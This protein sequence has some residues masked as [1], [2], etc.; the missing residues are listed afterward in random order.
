MT[1][2]KNQKKTRSN[3]NKVA[4]YE[5]LIYRDIANARAP[6]RVVTVVLAQQATLT[7]SAGGVFAGAFSMDPS[8]SAEWA[9]FAALYDQFRVIGGNLKIVSAIANGNTTVANGI[10]AFAFDNDSSAAPANY[11]QIMQFAEVTDVPACWTSGT[12]KQIPFRRP[13]KRGTPQSQF[14]WYDEASPSAS[15]G[16]LKFYGSGLSNSTTYWSYILE[17]VVQ[18]QLRA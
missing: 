14:L 4:K 9:S 6:N 13:M 10:V 17:Y 18:F 1:N 11:G 12:I 7:T 5:N 8:G 2:S 16:G 3:K 15:P